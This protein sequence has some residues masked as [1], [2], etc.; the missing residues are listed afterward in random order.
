M[1]MNFSKIQFPCHEKTSRRNEKKKE[2]E[3]K[4]EKKNYK[5]RKM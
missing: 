1:K 5:G 2:M 4:K 3:G